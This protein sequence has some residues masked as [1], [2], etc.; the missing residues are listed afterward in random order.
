MTPIDPR[1]QGKRLLVPPTLDDVLMALLHV[2]PDENPG[3]PEL[4][5]SLW[6]AARFELEKRNEPAAR[7][8]T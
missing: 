3:V 4:I 5:C 7:A 6:D 1:I 2:F 8:R